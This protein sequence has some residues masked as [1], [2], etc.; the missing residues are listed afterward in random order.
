MLELIDQALPAAQVL[1]ASGSSDEDARGFGLLFLL[2]G[3]VFYGIIYMRY[4][5]SDKRH[6][7]EAE[8]EAA[9]HEMRVSDTF[10]QSRKGLSNSKMQGANHNDV[11]GTVH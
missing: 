4:R 2:A 8:T 1:A 7:H 6:R 10:V 11:R 3:P 5:N 9:T